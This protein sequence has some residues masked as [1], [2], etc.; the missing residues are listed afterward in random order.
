MELRAIAC[1]EDQL[2][3]PLREHGPILGVEFDTLPPDAFGAPIGIY[4]NSSY[5]Y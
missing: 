4:D 1:V 2:G 5:L 3:E